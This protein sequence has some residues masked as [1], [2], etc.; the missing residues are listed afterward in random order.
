MM[1]GMPFDST[2]TI[3]VH[4]YSADMPQDLGLNLPINVR[5]SDKDP[6][7]NYVSADFLAGSSAIRRSDLEPMS[8]R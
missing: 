4:F 8:Y 5:W 7:G 1:I 3:K 6:N 2:D